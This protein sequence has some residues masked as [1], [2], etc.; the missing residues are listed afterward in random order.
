MSSSNVRRTSCVGARAL[1]AALGSLLAA[2]P[3]V[4]QGTGV[5][6]GRVTD[7]H[8]GAPLIGARVGIT[9][10][11]VA[12]TTGA[13]GAYRL[14]VNAG[15]VEL[16]ASAIGYGLSRTT[17]SVAADSTVVHDV[18]LEPAPVALEEL[19]VT[20]TRAPARSAGDAPVPVDVLTEAEI[21][22]SGRT[23]T[24]QIIQMLAPSFNFPRTSIA[25]GTDHTRPATLRG[26]APDQVLVLINGKRRHPSAL[27]NV[28]GTVGRGS[29]MVDLN[30]IPASAIERIE[31]LRDGAAA[32]YGS[33]AIAG[34]INIILKAN[35][36]SELSGVAGTTTT[37]DGEV[38]QGALG[39]RLPVGPR[40][41]LQL[42]AE[43]RHR[44]PTN[45]AGLDARP[46]Y[47]PGDPRNTGTPRA[48][49]WQGDGEVL[50][51]MVF[52]NAA[53]T[54]GRSVELYGFGG[55]AIRDGDAWGFFRRPLDDRTVRALHPDGFLPQIHSDISD[56]S[57]VVGLRG[58]WQGWRWDLSANGG[59]NGF[60]FRVLNSNN[61]TLGAAS[62]TTFYAGK[63][64]AGLLS[65]NLDAARSVAVGL[66]TPLNVAFGAEYRRDN[67]E[68]TPGE[69]ASYVD[70]GVRILDGPN[71][72]AR[73]A[74]GAQVFPGFRPSDGTR[75]HRTNVAAYADLEANLTAR[76][77]LGVAGR[78][79]D[80][81]D[82]GSEVTGKAAARLELAPAVALRGAV[83]NGFRAP[84]LGQ[85]W[86]S[87]TATNFINGVPFEN[88]TFPVADPVAQALGAQP[89]KAETSVNLSGGVTLQPTRAVSLTVDYYRITIDD[90]IVLS[91]NFNQPAVR[92][93]LEA[94]G[95]RGVS[96]ARFFT[97]AVDTRTR[98]VDLVAGY[99]ASL[100]AGLIRLT[101]G[102]NATETKVTNVKP[103]PGI[104]AQ[105][106]QTLFD[107][108][109]LVRMEKGQPKNSVLLSGTY[110]IGGVTLTLRTQR[111]G[112]FFV[113]SASSDRAQDQTFR[114]KW[115]SDASI[116]YRVAGRATLT[117]G[118]DN[119]FNAFPDQFSVPPAPSATVG[120]NS[121][122]GIN[123]WSGQ[124]PF[125]FNG[126]YV[127]GRLSLT[128]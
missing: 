109:E 111:Y 70:G 104:L 84:S 37:G 28:N 29:G 83:S 35:A 26:L 19:T 103:T 118:V 91:G 112:E 94:R 34:V 47:F 128:L 49:S 125:G 21:K 63:L 82:F 77:L 64:E 25:D 39:L 80:Y 93:F 32:Q 23:E 126:R 90:R 59:L 72:G 113:R 50:D 81:S 88:K 73:G 110:G 100:G 11:I 12:T 62:P 55:I 48:T 86:F 31:I 107:S 116:G 2:S 92:S 45:R 33:D 58:D 60:T 8:T 89:L 7:A 20:G 97:N 42:T 122:F 56:L 101:A 106:S 30:A 67:Y 115:V 9:G 76:L 57:G 40:G 99:A 87:S 61:V 43:Y 18:A 105:F 52:A 127:Y 51:R 75:R 74:V 124:S 69:P 15:T 123:R 36:A 71:R 38:L 53:Y 44:N 121:F 41:F 85:S 6:T 95:F 79:E 4:A 120:G 68:I 1:F 27:I 10:S 66:A 3:L 46:Q 5:V 117:I 14:R 17:L 119:A 98:G 114:A 65:F 13:N 54:L 22:S 24:A 108:V 102:V 96:G 16:R 78:Y